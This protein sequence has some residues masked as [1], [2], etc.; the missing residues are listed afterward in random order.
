M[1]RLTHD[2]ANSSISFGTAGRRKASNAALHATI[3]L[4]AGLGVNSLAR[5]QTVD[6]KSRADAERAVQA[7]FAMWS[8]N[9]GVN[10]AAVAR[11]YA[12]NVVYYGKRMSRAQVLADKQAYIR[13]WPV[14]SYREVPGTFSARCTADLGLCHVT[15]DMAWRRASRSGAVSTGRATIGFD[16]V[17]AD[18]GRKIARESARL[19]D[20]R[21]G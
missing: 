4:A 6:G 2:Y 17:P 19:F 7:Y 15:T 3:L 12:P 20:D 11:F 13:A 21:R 14:R 18:G 1:I 10:A 5:A 8:N 16:F 9:A